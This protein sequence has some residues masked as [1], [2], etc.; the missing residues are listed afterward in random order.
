MKRNEPKYPDDF[1]IYSPESTDGRSAW[2]DLLEFA[3]VWGTALA[4]AV[5]FVAWVMWWNHIGYFG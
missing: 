2:W 5:A 1:E 4:F 3:A